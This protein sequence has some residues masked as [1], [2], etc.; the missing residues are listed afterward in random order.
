MAA[1]VTLPD[2]TTS[3]ALTVTTR[4]LGGTG[5]PTPTVAGLHQVVWT[6]GGERR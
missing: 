6:A 1:V 4:S 3:P 2:L 5:R